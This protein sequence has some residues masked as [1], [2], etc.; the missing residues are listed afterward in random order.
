MMLLNPRKIR[1]YNLLGCLVCQMVYAQHLEIGP[2]LTNPSLQKKIV[3]QSGETIDSTFI[4]STD[5]LVLPLFDDFSSNKFQQYFEDYG[6]PSI[7]SE[8]Y[9]YLSNPVTSLPLSADVQYTNQQTF[10]RTFNFL[11]DEFVDEIFNPTSV[12]VADLDNFP[13]Q[14]EQLSLYPPY[15]LYDTINDININT[16]DTVWLT[17]PQYIQDSARVFF[18]TVSDPSKYWLDESVYWNHRFAIDPRSVGVA[19][20]DGLD[21]NGNPYQYGSISPNYADALTSKTIDLS[22][23][24]ASD[25]IYLSF[26]YQPQGFGDEPENSDSLIVEFYQANGANWERVW[27]VEGSPTHPF[28]AATIPVLDSEYFTNGFKFR[29][30]NY[31][32]LAGALDHFHIDYVHLRS[33][34]YASDTLFKDFAFS[35]PITSLLDKYTSVPWDHYQN[36]DENRM[37]DSLEV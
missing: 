9:Y 22:T 14:Y 31:G 2:M 24:G 11:T 10:K 23:F 4:F 17:N 26:L 13:V 7:T 33:L 32:S 15:Y 12:K 34:S 35:Y 1:I 5:T 20:F 37:T 16:T 36:S 6:D 29:F 19:T 25:S 8:L 3:K 18:Q 30:R 28:K 21:K 27:S